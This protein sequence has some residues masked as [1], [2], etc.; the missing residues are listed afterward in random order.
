[1]CIFFSLLL[2]VVP[3]VGCDHDFVECIIAV[4][5]IYGIIRHMHNLYMPP[6]KISMSIVSQM[7]IKSIFLPHPTIKQLPD[8]NFLLKS[9]TRNFNVR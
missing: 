9:I 3:V 2:S 7:I 1:M 8:V 6:T 5:H 4:C